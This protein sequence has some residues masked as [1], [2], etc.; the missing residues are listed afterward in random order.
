MYHDPDFA[1]LA[2]ILPPAPVVIDVGGNIGQSIVS[3]KAARPQALISSFEP[4]PALIPQLR[5]TAQRFE[6]VRV[7]ETGLGAA[8]TAMTFHIP[9]VGGVRYLEECT[10]RLESLQEPWVVERFARRGGQPSFETFTAAVVP[11]DELALQPDLIKVDVE[12]VES[13]V[14]AGFRE[15]IARHAPILLVENG[16]WTRLAPIIQS[17]GYSPWMANE[18]YDGLVPFSGARTNTFYLKDR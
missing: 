1:V 12:G 16:D 11:G 9:V 2:H 4:N 14:V 3:I 5:Q 17:L 7:F 18:R 10:M 8:R 13:E 15:T 6:D